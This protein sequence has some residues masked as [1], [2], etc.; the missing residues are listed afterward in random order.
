MHTGLID[1]IHRQRDGCVG[2]GCLPYDASDVHFATLELGARDDLTI[3]GRIKDC[4]RWSGDDTLFNSQL[5]L[6]PREIIPG[7]YM[8]SDRNITLVVRIDDLSGE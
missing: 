3:G 1:W 4:D 2:D 6:R 8:I 5:T 7:D